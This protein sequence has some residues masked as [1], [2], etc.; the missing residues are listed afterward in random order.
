MQF[1]DIVF[2]RSDQRHRPDSGTSVSHSLRNK[3]CALILLVEANLRLQ[4]TG[5]AT[6]TPSGSDPKTG[7]DDPGWKIFLTPI[8]LRPDVVRQPK[9]RHH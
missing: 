9:K 5:S 8:H 4:V 7:G 2:E 3:H 1:H 6:F